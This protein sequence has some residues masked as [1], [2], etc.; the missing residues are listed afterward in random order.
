MYISNIEINNFRNF[1]NISIDFRDG[2]N[3]LIGQNNAGKSNVLKALA[4]VFDNKI[5]KQL[6][7]DDFFNNIS[8]EDIKLKS[9]KISISVSLSQSIDE[10][11]MEDELAIVG[12]WIVSLEQ[13]YVAKVHYEFFLPEDYEQEYLDLIQEIKSQDDA[14]KIINNHFIRLYVSKIW[15][16]NPKNKIQI[17]RERLSKFDFQFLDAI[18]D[19]ERDMFSGKNT[20]LKSII[21]FFIDY[22]IKSDKTVSLEEQSKRINERKQDF[23]L[24]SYELIEI[25]KKRL[26]KGTDEILLYSDNIGASF[27]KSHPALEGKIT[28]SEIYSVLQL[29]IKQNSGISIPIYNNGLGYNNLIFMSLLLAKMQVDSDGKYLGSNAKVFPILVIEEHEA[30]L[31][32]TMQFQ[33]MKFLKD[34]LGCKK[35]KQVFITSHSTHITSSEQLDNIICLYK[36][37]YETKVAYPGKVF[38]DKEGDKEIKNDKSKKY[39]QRFLDATKSNMLF[40]EKI[41][42]VEGKAE[43]LLIPVFAEYLGKSLEENH[44]T[45]I[46]VGGRCFEHFLYLFNSYNYGTIKRRIACITDLDPC[47]KDINKENDK[48]QN[49]KACYPFE[50]NENCDKYEYQLNPCMEK[51]KKSNN[52]NICFF[53]QNE[54]YGKTLEYQLAF[55]NPD[56][57]LLLTPSLKNKKELKGLMKMY[58]DGKSLEEMLKILKESDENNRIKTSILSVRNKDIWTHEFQKRAVIAARYLNSIEKGENALELSS[59][60]YEY[61]LKDKSL[62]HKDFN[63]PEYIKEA[64]D[65]VCE[66][67]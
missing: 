29:I 42:F 48:N 53:T 22:D 57:E 35:V 54:N 62:E 59:I 67:A 25:L 66:D 20:L 55:E 33:L 26:D 28:E 30:H 39:V 10:A 56:C 60:L 8:L 61:I 32:P 37:K 12:D 49:F 40:S 34:N 19:V 16:G 36:D 43:Q 46:D 18:R 15:G 4:L 51:Y 58:S 21:N 38:F 64:I 63:I 7:I 2:I 9:P 5:R 44:I 17:D 41:I 14:R 23:E 65:W 47:R 13:P 6:T 3:I 31:H 45:V 52:S 11:L 50:I 24:K 1:K 27:D